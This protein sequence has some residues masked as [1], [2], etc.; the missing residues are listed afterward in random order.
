MIFAVHLMN[1]GTRRA[2]LLILETLYENDTCLA[3][4]STTLTFFSYGPPPA[5]A[6]MTMLLIMVKIVELKSQVD[7]QRGSF[8]G[9]N[10][11][12]V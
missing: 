10:V 2:P 9:M 8:W 3:K 5:I 11:E 6:A 4:T 1:E 7:F 12:Y